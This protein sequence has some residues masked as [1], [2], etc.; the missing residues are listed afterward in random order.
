MTQIDISTKSVLIVGV[1]RNIGSTLDLD[2]NRMVNA[3][4]SFKNVH[5]FLV[6]SDSNDNSLEALSKASERYPNFSYVSL[7]KLEKTFLMR[8]ERL[9]HARNVYLEEFENNEAYNSCE[10]IAVSDFNNLNKLLNRTAVESVFSSSYWSARTANQSGPYYDIW[11]LRHPA[12]SPNDCWENLEF[13]RKYRKFPELALYAAVNSRM[14]RI[15]KNSSP[16]SVDSAFGGFA[17]YRREAI[18]G[19]RY[20]G[21]LE[22]TRSQIC[23]HVPLNLEITNERGVIEVFPSLINMRKTDHTRRFGVSRSLLRILSYLPKYALKIFKK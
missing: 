21:I 16:I 2:I 6:E 5:F 1:V 4:T 3:F 17:I 10:F 14:I 7:G 15:P 19:K 22:G 18:E 13:L 12:W 20:K 9:A 11:A 23:E 8:T